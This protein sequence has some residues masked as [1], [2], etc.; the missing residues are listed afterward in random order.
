MAES[1]RSRPGA[2]QSGGD[3]LRTLV[4]NLA[5]DLDVKVAFICE[6]VDEEH[7]RTLALSVDGRILDNL[8]YR[9][10]GT[11]CAG[12]YEEGRSYLPRETAAAF[13]QDA[14]LA[15][16]N[17]DAYLGV[18]FFDAGGKPMG[19]VGIMNDRHL[20]D[21]VRC[22]SRLRE[23]AQRARTEVERRREHSAG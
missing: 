10:A 16:W 22:E 9:L 14:L 18:A 15:D 13:P 8:R 1:R 2:E 17:I 23:D 19:H 20:T 7:A 21:V 11:P 6:L 12:V 5:R 4:R 3:P